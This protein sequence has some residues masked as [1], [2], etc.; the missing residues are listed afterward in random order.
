MVHTHLFLRAAGHHPTA[1]HAHRNFVWIS[2]NPCPRPHRRQPAQAAARGPARRALLQQRGSPCAAP[3]QAPGA[4]TS[5]SMVHT[6]Y[7]QRAR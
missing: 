7:T 2:T 4:S 5:Q 1:Q 3:P 6:T